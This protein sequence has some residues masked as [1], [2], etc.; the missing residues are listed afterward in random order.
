MDPCTLAVALSQPDIEIAVPI[1][2]DAT[3][4]ENMRPSLDLLCISSRGWASQ[5]TGR[6]DLVGDISLSRS[7]DYQRHTSAVDRTEP[8]ARNVFDPKDPS[9]I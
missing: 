3:K 9:C 5:I 7:S 2:R 8:S 4:R 6:R 1:M